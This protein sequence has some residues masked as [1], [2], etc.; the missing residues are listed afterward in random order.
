MKNIEKNTI[1]K[2]NDLEQSIAEAVAVQRLNLCNSLGIKDRLINLSVQSKQIEREAVAA[3]LVLC[4]ALDVFPEQMFDLKPCSKKQGT[5]KGDI[6][7]GGYNVDVKY[8]RY[9]TGKLFARYKYEAKCIDSYC[10]ITQEDEQ[11]YNIRGFMTASDLLQD[12]RVGALGSY[13][14]RPCF[15]AEQKELYDYETCLNK[16]LDKAA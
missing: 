8:T 5:D 11:V 9:K 3:E 15:I 14:D 16:L 13:K 2:L 7:L 6:V 4:K 12:S 1:I 10:L